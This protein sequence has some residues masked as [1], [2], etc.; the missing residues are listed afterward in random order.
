MGDVCEDSVYRL[1]R[2]EALIGEIREYLTRVGCEVFEEGNALVARCGPCLLR[3]R[4]EGLG[5]ER[6]RRDL[7][8]LGELAAAAGAEDVRLMIEVSE[9]C[10]RVCDLVKWRALMK[11]GG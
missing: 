11:G 10:E 2:P 5:Q 1:T 9:G 6:L 3:A 8:T 7:G 4:A